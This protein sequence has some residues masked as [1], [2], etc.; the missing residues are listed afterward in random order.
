MVDAVERTVVRLAPLDDADLDA[1]LSAYDPLDKAG[2]YVIQGPGALVIEAVEGCY[3][4]VVGLPLNALD[5]LFHR[6]GH[7]LLRDAA[8]RGDGA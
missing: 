7:S 3:Y 1:F 2:A 5:R 6:F 8:F 4:N